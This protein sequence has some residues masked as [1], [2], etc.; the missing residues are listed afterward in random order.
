MHWFTSEGLYPPPGAVWITFLRWIYP[1]YFATKPLPLFTA[2]ISYYTAW[3]WVNHGVIFFFG[4]TIPL[5]QRCINSFP[6]RHRIFRYSVIHSLFWCI[7]CS[8]IH[9]S[10]Y[11]GAMTFLWKSLWKQF[12]PGTFFPSDLLLSAFP[13]WSKVPRRLGKL[14]DDV[15]L[16]AFLNTKYANFRLASSVVRTSQV[17]PSS[18]NSCGQNDASPVILQRAAYLITSVSSPWLLQFSSLYLQ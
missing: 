13:L 12:V 6:T 10:K 11:L 15:G 3:G 14:S 2:I 9:T 16:R 17:R 4:W 5:M 18:M 1:L 8:D 7:A